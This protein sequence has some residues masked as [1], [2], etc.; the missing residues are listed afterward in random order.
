MRSLIQIIEAR[1]WRPA[2]QLYGVLSYLVAMPRQAFSLLIS[3]ST[4]FLSLYRSGSWLTGRPPLEPFHLSARLADHA[5]RRFLR[6]E[7]TWP[8]AKAFTTAWH[9]LTT[10]PAVT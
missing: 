3:R 2:R 1:R 5:F 9:R 4:V 6:I 10:L 7:R 8:W